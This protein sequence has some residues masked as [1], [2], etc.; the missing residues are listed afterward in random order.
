M[1]RA[2]TAEEDAFLREHFPYD[3]RLSLS[4]RLLADFGSERSPAAVSQRAHALGLG[5]SDWQ[6]PRRAERKVWWHLEPAMQ[7]W[8]EARDCGQ[9]GRD[10]S[11]EFMGEFGFPL[12]RA[13]VTLWRQANGRTGG[14]GHN[15]RS[16]EAVPV[17]TVRDT[18]KGYRVVKVAERSTVPGS[19]DNW[20]PAHHLAWEA[21]NG[22]SVPEGFTVLH[23]DGNPGND[24]PANLVLVEKSLVGVM[25]APGS[26]RWSSAAECEACAALARLKRAE[27][28]AETALPRPCGVCG[29]MFSPP[30]ESARNA[31]LRNARTCPECLAAGRKTKG[32]GIARSGPASAVCAVCGREFEKSQR[33]QSRCPECIAE[34]P[35][36]AAAAHARQRARMAAT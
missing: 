5:K 36:W 10:L 28:A 29:K 8:M 18:G 23:G 27:C 14:A 13:Q 2:W 24:D 16:F 30:R 7:E 33:N 11:R 25:N 20:R 9:D 6:P 3:N 32:R 15:G 4:R 35:K 34:H 1:A 26:P 21:A 12:S 31:G 17:G 19:K 22:Q